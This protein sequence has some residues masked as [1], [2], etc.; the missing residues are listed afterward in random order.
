[1]NIS[2]NL[3]RSWNLPTSGSLYVSRH[4][5]LNV[6]IKSV[7]PH[8]SCIIFLYE[9]RFNEYF[10]QSVYDVPHQNHMKLIME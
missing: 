10:T 9:K 8:I 3:S 6:I 1:M 7:Q 5:S 4:D 2:T